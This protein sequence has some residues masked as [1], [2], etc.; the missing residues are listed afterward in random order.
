M[1]NVIPAAMAQGQAQATAE[2]TA[3]SDLDRSNLLRLTSGDPLLSLLGDLYIAD[4][5]SIIVDGHF[6]DA[7]APG[8]AAPEFT[9]LELLCRDG[10]IPDFVCRQRYGE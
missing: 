2:P 6:L 9:F 5:L 4:L 10:D 1:P 7:F 3:Q 8:E